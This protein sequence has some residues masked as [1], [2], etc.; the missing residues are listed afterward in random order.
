MSSPRE[1]NDDL[2]DN[3]N[4]TS[5]VGLLFRALDLLRD[6]PDGSSLLHGKKKKR[7]EKILHRIIGLLVE[8]SK[9]NPWPMIFHVRMSENLD[10]LEESRF[11]YYKRI[12][13]EYAS[14][15]HIKNAD[16][17]QAQLVENALSFLRTH[18]HDPDSALIGLKLSSMALGKIESGEGSSETLGTIAVS[19][20]A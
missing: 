3:V 5:T 17:E 20:F 11:K 6:Q 2:I 13:E 4:A 1:P 10:V 16:S 18:K 9:A 19:M 15:S 7:K 8:K 14:T 12:F